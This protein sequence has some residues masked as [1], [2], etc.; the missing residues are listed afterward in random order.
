MR[1]I[2]GVARGRRILAPEGV[3]TRPMTDEIK[4]ALF[5]MLGVVDGLRVLDSYAG[6]GAIGLEALSRGAASVDGVEQSRLAAEIIRRNLASL[7]FGD[8]YRLFE[9]P[10]ETWLKRAQA[11]PAAYDLIFADP[12][13]GK[14]EGAVLNQLAGLLNANGL[15]IVRYFHKLEQPKPSGT[16]LVKSRRYG[17]SVLAIYGKY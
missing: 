14:L 15:L 7:G 17:D 9:Q 10:I 13:F 11:K 2:G 3:K 5:N 16:R 6:S 4:E 1:I 12:P 8:S